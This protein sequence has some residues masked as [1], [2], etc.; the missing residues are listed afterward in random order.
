MA[1]FNRIVILGILGHDP[2]LKFTKNNRPFCRISLATHS[3]RKDS[4]SATT[5]HSIHVFGKEAENVVKY[6][7]KGRQILVEGRIESTR[8]VD[9]DQKENWRTWIH[10][11]HITFMNRAKNP[12][13][14][15]ENH[16]SQAA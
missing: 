3:W 14:G 11:D 13:D 15:G 16:E 10:A 7:Q 5:W 1:T 6:L 2:E 4:G 9:I 8:F 12:D